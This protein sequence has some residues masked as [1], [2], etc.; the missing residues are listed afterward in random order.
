[1]APNIEFNVAQGT[2]MEFKESFDLI[3]SIEVLNIYLLE[4][5]LVF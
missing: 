4:K 1:M 2:D 3:I 5:K